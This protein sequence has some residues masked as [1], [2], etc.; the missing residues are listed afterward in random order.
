MLITSFLIGF[1]GIKNQKRAQKTKFVDL[2]KVDK[3]LIFS[4]KNRLL[5]EKFLRTPLVRTQDL[6]PNYDHLFGRI[7]LI[8]GKF[9]FSAF[10]GTI[11]QKSHYLPSDTTLNCSKNVWVGQLKMK[12]N[13]TNAGTFWKTLE[14]RAGRDAEFTKGGG[15]GGGGGLEH[16]WDCTF[17]FSVSFAETLKNQLILKQFSASQF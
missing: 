8:S 1:F 2:K 3:T 15:G 12:R 10:F 16:A 11:D 4:P 13:S 7:M 17:D 5:L 9:R 14:L 6:L